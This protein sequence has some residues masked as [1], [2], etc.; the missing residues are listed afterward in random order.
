MQMYVHTESEKK[1]KTLLHMEFNIFF[2]FGSRL[3]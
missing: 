2:F 3:K 1:R